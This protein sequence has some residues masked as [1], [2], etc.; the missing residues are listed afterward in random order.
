M[1]RNSLFFL[2]FFFCFVL[3]LSFFN[4]PLSAKEVGIPALE[5]ANFTTPQDNTYFPKAIGYTYIYEAEEE[6]GLLR[7]EIEISTDTETIL[8][9]TCTVVYDVEWIFI[10][11]EDKWFILEETEDWYAWDNDGSVWYFG[12][13]TT[14]YLYDDEWS[15]VGTSSEGSWKA[16][17]DGALAG[18]VMLANPKVGLSYQQEYYEDVAEDMGKVLRLDARVS[19]EM[20]DYDGCLKT[21]EWT[22]LEPGAIEHKYYA[23]EVGLVYIE[24]LKEKTVQVELVEIIAP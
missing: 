4:E 15:Q 23:P 9:V 2:V 8:G 19:I 7:N 10:E 18:I 24:E 17:V 14:E 20:G 3:P 21:K 11:E 16:G 12:E 6:D 13:D 1:S 22:A 5:P